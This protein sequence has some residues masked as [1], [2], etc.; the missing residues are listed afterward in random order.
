VEGSAA[1][2]A[3]LVLD[4]AAPP[5]AAAPAGRAWGLALLLRAELEARETLAPP[6]RAALAEARVAARALS[7][8]A[9]PAALPARLARYDL[10]GRRPGPFAARLALVLASATGRL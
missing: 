10:A 7:A 4:P 1:R 8:A 6:L 2:A 3:A 5:E 9:F